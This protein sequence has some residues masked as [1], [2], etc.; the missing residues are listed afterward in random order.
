M[1]DSYEE[2]QAARRGRLL[3]ERREHMKV[4]NAA[5]RKAGRPAPDNVEGWTAVGEATGLSPEELQKLRLDMARFGALRDTPY[6]GYAL[7][8]I[9]AEVRRVRARIEELR[10]ASDAERVGARVNRCGNAAQATRLWGMGF[11]SP[12]TYSWPSATSS[13]RCAAS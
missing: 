2:K 10:E 1:T 11:G 6:P 13:R 5:W 12:L 8:N 4:V 7:R 9:G 3:E